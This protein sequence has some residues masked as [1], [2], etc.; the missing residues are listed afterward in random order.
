MSL[1]QEPGDTRKALR[2]DCLKLWLH[3]LALLDQRL[4]QRFDPEDTPDLQV[5]P[6][7]TADGTSYPPGADPALI[8]DPVAR[9][10]YQQAIRDNQVKIDRYGQ[11]VRLHRLSERIEPRAESFIR[12]SYTFAP[13]DREEARAAILATIKSPRRQA[14]L[15]KACYEID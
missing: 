8:E 6:P 5:Q 14:I 15:L 2:A 10:A 13:S 12:H 11:Q 3:L 4:D 1:T 7:D 9:A